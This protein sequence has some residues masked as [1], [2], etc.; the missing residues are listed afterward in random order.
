MSHKSGYSRLF[1]E[2]VA[3][4]D[5]AQMPA[6]VAHVADQQ[7]AVVAL[8]ARAAHHAVRAA[9]F[10]APPSF[11]GLHKWRNAKGMHALATIIAE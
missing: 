5:A 9:P 3:Y 6:T 8:L 11:T 1:Q 2:K 7:S 10:A 4:H